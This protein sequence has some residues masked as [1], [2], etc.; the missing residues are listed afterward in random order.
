[1]NSRINSIFISVL[2]LCV[3]SQNTVLKVFETERNQ[4]YRHKA[5]KMYSTRSI[6]MAFTFA[7]VP[8]ILATSM[9]FS[10]VFYFFMGTSWTEWLLV[11][12]LYYET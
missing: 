2:F 10:V 6:L 3:S 11:K 8:F 4:F 1:M 9:A 12:L 7:E 5:C